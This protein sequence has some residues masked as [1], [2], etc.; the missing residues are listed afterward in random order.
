MAAKITQIPNKQVHDTMVAESEG[1]PTVIYVSNSSLPA[2]KAFTPKYE[3]LADEHDRN[4]SSEY[5][6]IPAER[7]IR[8]CQLDFSNE[9]SMMF[10][11]SPNQLPVV[12]LISE[13]CWCRTLM[14]PSV[15]E[16]ESGIGE[17]LK[18]AGR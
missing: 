12:V 4:V 8:F 13:G 5:A 11:F 9:T 16:L 15:K 3:A 18:K 14:S 17:L 1:T 2:C 7:S 10:K 6:D